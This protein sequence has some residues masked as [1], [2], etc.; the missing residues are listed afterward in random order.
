MG[1]RKTKEEYISEIMAKAVANN[2]EIKTNLKKLD[3][4]ILSTKIK[5]YHDEC[6]KTRN[7]KVSSFL[8]WPEC[9]YCAKVNKNK[10][11]IT[12]RERAY[13]N[14]PKPK[15]GEKIPIREIKQKNKIGPLKKGYIKTN[16][17][18]T[19]GEDEV[20]RV[21]CELKV[22]YTV[23][24]EIYLN[25]FSKTPLRADFCV[26]LNGINYLIEYDGEQHFRP[27]KQYGGTK[28]YYRTM[29]LDEAKDYFVSRNRKTYK[30]LRIPYWEFKNIEFHIRNYLPLK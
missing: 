17:S 30:I 15:K 6:K 2:V 14:Y 12:R 8:E 25:H 9:Q 24:H 10:K 13:S 3:K 27:I 5:I 7:S 1:K 22:P 28:R 23:E 26:K 4:L 19:K 18:S 11:L 20:A 29:R 16:K 21:L